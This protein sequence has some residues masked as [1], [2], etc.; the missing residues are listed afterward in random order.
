VEECRAGEGFVGRAGR[1]LDKINLVGGLPREVIGLT[2]VVKRTPDDTFT[3]PDFKRAFYVREKVGRKTVTRPSPELLEW[4]KVLALELAEVRPNVVVACGAEALQALCGLGSITNYRGSILPS[5]LVPGL[6]VIPLLH[7]SYILRKALWQE[8]FIAGWLVRDK[9]V[10]QGLFPEIRYEPWNEIVDP[11][12]EEIERFGAGLIESQAP[13][14]LDIENTRTKHKVITHVG[15]AYGEL[16]HEQAISVP[17]YDTP[18]DDRFW[19]LLQHIINGN[20]WITGHNFFHDMG[21]LQAYGVNVP[22]VWMDSMIAFHRLYPE[23]PKKLA[24]CSMLFT[25]IPYYKAEGKDWSKKARY[26]IKD[27]VAQIRV[28]HR[29]LQE[30]DANPRAYKLYR[31]HTTGCLQW[32]FEMQSRGMEV[33]DTNRSIAQVTIY[34]EL[35][36]VRERLGGLTAGELV[37]RAGNKTVTDKQVQDYLY[38]TLGLPIKTKRGTGKVTSEEDALVELLIAHPEHQVIK[39][40]IAD[41]KLTKARDS[42]IDIEYTDRKVV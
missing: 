6:K 11:S 26:N 21:W 24:F 34:T 29:L 15:M 10:P 38:K 9:V 28:V 7:P 25:D 18:P 40:I 14:A 30:F 36:A 27:C 12:F 33:N 4:Y 13:W 37:V 31:E 20:P 35:S 42:Y 8:L 17:T 5:S 3:D 41:R 22:H 16:G 32:A 1:L 23:L 39:Y 2:N 19:R